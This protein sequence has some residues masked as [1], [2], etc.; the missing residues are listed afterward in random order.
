MKKME[1]KSPL[2]SHNDLEVKVIPHSP[3]SIDEEDLSKR[4]MKEHIA[5]NPSNTSNNNGGQIP[6][7]EPNELKVDEV[8]LEG[9]SNMVNL[10]PCKPS[11]S[12]MGDNKDR[13]V[14]SKTL[15]D[16]FNILK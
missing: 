8:Q 10:H 7:L 4:K 3:K 16:I 13:E 1:G 2:P 6:P 11:E 5:E 12:L 14:I 15:D 9:I